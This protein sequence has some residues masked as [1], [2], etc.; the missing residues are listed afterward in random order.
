MASRYQPLTLSRYNQ[1]LAQRGISL[2]THLEET[3]WIHTVQVGPVISVGKKHRERNQLAQSRA[4]YA[5]WQ[6]RFPS[7]SVSSSSS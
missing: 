6:K 5:A 1:Q 2:A 4:N 3:K 7:P